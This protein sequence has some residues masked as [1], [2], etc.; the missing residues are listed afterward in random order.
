MKKTAEEV[1]GIERRCPECHRPLKTF[2]I[3]REDAKDLVCGGC[4]REF[5]CAELAALDPDA[6][7]E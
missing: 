3:P 2:R 5:T 4:G 7:A 6:G 1:C